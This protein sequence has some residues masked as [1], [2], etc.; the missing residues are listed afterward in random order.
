[1]TSAEIQALTAMRRHHGDTPIGHRSAGLAKQ[2][3]ALPSHEPQP[4]ATHEM[5]T[6]SWLIN[7]RAGELARLAV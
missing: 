5:Q 3:Q 1:M 6:L 2:L 7:R 4:W